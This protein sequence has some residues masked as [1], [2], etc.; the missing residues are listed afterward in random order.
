MGDV[1]NFKLRRRVNAWSNAA[2]PR[3]FASKYQFFFAA[4]ILRAW[5]SLN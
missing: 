2:N 3:V 1:W 5:S 4:S